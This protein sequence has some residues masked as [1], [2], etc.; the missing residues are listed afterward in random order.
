MKRIVLSAILA[1]TVSTTALAET[2]NYTSLTDLFGEPVTTSA[3]G[4][5]QRASEAPVSIDIISRAEIDK[6]GAKDIPELLRRVPGLNVSRSD[7]HSVDVGIR[8]FNRFFNQNLLVLVNGRQVYLDTYGMTL[9][10]GIP[11]QMDEIQQIEV[12]RGPNTA[13]FG[14]NAAAGVVNIVTKSPLYDN[15]NSASVTLGTNGT[16]GASLVKT[17]KFGETG[18]IRL[19]AG[20]SEADRFTAKGRTTVRDAVRD[21]SEYS[22]SADGLF[23]VNDAIQAGFEVTHANVDQSESLGIG[24]LY[25]SSYRTSS[26]K[27]YFNA[28]VNDGDIFS[29]QVYRNWA[30]VGYNT[31]G[32]TNNEVTVAQLAYLTDL[33]SGHT[34]RVAGEYRANQADVFPMNTGKMKFDVWSASGMWNWQ[35]FD[36]FAV[37]A[38]GRV[39]FMDNTRTGYLPA[40]TPF[41]LDDYDKDTLYSYNLGA[42]WN[43]TDIDTVRVA[44]GRGVSTPSLI[45]SSFTFIFGT[46]LKTGLW[47]VPDLD[48][49]T[50]TSYEVGYSRK[51]EEIDGAVSVTG[52]YQRVKGIRTTT[53]GVIPSYV[54]FTKPVQIGLLFRNAGKSEGYGFEVEAHGKFTPELSWNLAYTWV[55]LNDKLTVNQFGFYDHPIGFENQAPKNTLS[56]ELL[57][58]KKD[59]WVKT[60]LYYVD[61]TQDYRDVGGGL[62]NVQISDYVIANV[63][64]GYRVNENLDLTVDVLNAQAERTAIS[65]FPKQERRG[66][67]TARYRF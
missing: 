40:G 5:P 46:Q 30:K 15:E 17:L 47:G 31:L 26:A 12:V 20:G 66:I 29:G 43:V 55:D 41:T 18:G 6:A 3:T 11:V 21:A 54:D 62:A 9:W 22:F 14:F 50:V 36:N 7:P 64:A 13:L 42:V 35:M 45:D 60:G 4:K 49:T 34:V 27:L 59:W 44:T 19:S 16:R 1:S 37:N 24:R 56:A 32:S 38:A 58:D 61:E 65:V 28:N 8:G 48:A 53:T 63:S 52:F 10:S 23:Q 57:Y 25:D 39:D 2:I 51:V 33:G 67:V